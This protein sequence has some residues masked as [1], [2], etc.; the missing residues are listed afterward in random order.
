MWWRRGI[1]IIALLTVVGC[2]N[3]SNTVSNGDSGSDTE[4]AA[5]TP[6]AE[7]T[8]ESTDDTGSTD[9]DTTTAEDTTGGND[10]TGGGNDDT[11]GGGMDTASEETD[12]G[13][14]GVDCDNPA[15]SWLF[16][17]DFETGDG[18][19]ATWFEASDFLTSV[20]EDNRDRIRLSDTHATSG[21]WSVHMPAAA[22]ADYQGADLGWYACEG[23]QKVNCDMTGYDKLYFR[24]RVR[25][26][27]D[28]NYVHHFLNIRGMD[29]F[30]SYGKAGC[31]PNGESTMGTTVDFRK[32]SHNTFFY[33]Y[34]LDMNCDTN[35]G[36]Y[37]DVDKFCQECADKGFPTCTQQK[38]CCWG[39]NF[40]PDPPKPLPTGEWF[41][42]E[43]MM[44][45]N[46]PGNSDGKMAYWIDG[47]LG[48]EVDGMRWR[49]TEDLQLNQARLQHYIAENDADKPNKVWF[50]DVVVSTE[51][52]GCP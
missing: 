18:D 22:S 17:E 3:P 15:S 28:H 6:S 12:G 33:T 26:A 14:D 42:F 16:C 4:S 24:A 46:T 30:W 7:D 48:H 1:A 2:T 43:M 25:F 21:D 10:D 20:G 37:A 19:W 31:L 11:G 40:E 47:D 44:E 9:E 8:E 51:R 36:D 38:Q 29:R 45:A 39:D 52:V 5:D 41:C 27:P 13:S 34:H 49:T 50:D 32:D 35:C 23:E